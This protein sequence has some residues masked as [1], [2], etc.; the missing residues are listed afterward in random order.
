MY[1]NNHYFLLTIIQLEIGIG[2][3]RI[4][5]ISVPRVTFDIATSQ[6]RDRIR[7]DILVQ[8][9]QLHLQPA[10]AVPGE[11]NFIMRGTTLAPLCQPAAQPSAIKRQPAWSN[12][13]NINSVVTFNLSVQVTAPSPPSHIRD[14]GSLEGPSFARALSES[15][16]SS[17]DE[18]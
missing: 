16:P 7:G 2:I 1:F 14:I 18:T 6:H 13:W 10:P 8:S 5:P 12:W 9:L 15:E 4:G 17:S 11:T 3:S